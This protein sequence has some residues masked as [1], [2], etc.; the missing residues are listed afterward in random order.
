MAI[1]KSDWATGQHTVP[2]NGVAGVVHFQR[3]EF[4]VND[5]L[6]AGDIIELAVLPAGSTV[7]DALLSVGDTA[8]ATVG[9]GIMSGHVGEDD[10]NRTA[11]TEL[12]AAAEANTVSRAEAATAFTIKPVDRDRSIGA[13]VSE[14]VTASGQLVVLNLFYKQ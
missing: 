7:V 5:D 3:F 13:E 8:T 14:E 4:V 2:L 12:F 6:A 9:V 10:D 11:G 1:V